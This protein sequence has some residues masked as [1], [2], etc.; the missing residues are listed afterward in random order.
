MDTLYDLLNALLYSYPKYAQSI[1]P[2][3]LTKQ[4]VIMAHLFRHV[5]ISV[6]GISASLATSRHQ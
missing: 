2:M 4:D 3:G 6:L 5:I 1:H